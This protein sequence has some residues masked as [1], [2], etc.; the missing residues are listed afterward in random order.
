MTDVTDLQICIC[1]QEDQ[2]SLFSICADVKLAEY[3]I[4]YSL[5]MEGQ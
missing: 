4:S 1:F 2:I 5:A 3:Q